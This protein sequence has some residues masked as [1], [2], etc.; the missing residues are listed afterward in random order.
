MKSV[1]FLGYHLYNDILYDKH[2]IHCDIKAQIPRKEM[3]KKQLG[4][5]LK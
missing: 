3:P 5:N 2:K 1:L 4:S